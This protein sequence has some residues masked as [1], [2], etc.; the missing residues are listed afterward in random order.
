MKRRKR[1]SRRQREEA[2]DLFERKASPAPTPAFCLSPSLPEGWGFSFAVLDELRVG[3]C[4]FSKLR[5]MRSV[6]QRVE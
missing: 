6:E 1:Q 4:A 5:R 3:L 2:Q